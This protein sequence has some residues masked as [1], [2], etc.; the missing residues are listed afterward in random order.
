MPT[1]RSRPGL[2]LPERSS[3]A[4]SRLLQLLHLRCCDIFVMRVALERAIMEQTGHRSLPMVRRYIRDGS[5][6]RQN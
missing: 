5:L 2:H 3:C 1:C 6:S 4:H